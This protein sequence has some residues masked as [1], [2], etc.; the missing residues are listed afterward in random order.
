MSLIYKIVEK[1]C[2]VCERIKPGLVKGKMMKM[3]TTP[4]NSEKLPKSFY[5]QFDVH[6]FFYKEYPIYQIKDK[7]VTSKKAVVFL[8]GGGGIARPTILHFNTVREIARKTKANVYFAYYPL[9]PKHNVRDALKWL[10]H[11]YD[12]IVK[13]YNAENIVLVGDSA[14]AN[15][16]V[17]LTNRVVQKPGG[18]IVISPASGLEDGKNRDIRLMMESKDPILSVEMND[19]IKDCWAKGMELDNPDIN[20][21]SAN[22]EFFPQM[23]FLYG[24]HEVFYPHVKNMLREIRK[25][26]IDFR[27]H[28]EPMCHD[29]ALCNFFPEGRIAMNEMCDFINS[30]GDHTD[31]LTI[32]NSE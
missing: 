25:M 32:P 26:G 30:L 23:F 24:T 13:K 5:K 9:A 29:W 21:A 31:V 1:A 27:V 3:F 14:G 22:Y 6:N 2:F 19:V 20:P 17:S 10:E 16:V 15:L 7:L 28:E 18:I 4:N 11:I 8:A 12:R